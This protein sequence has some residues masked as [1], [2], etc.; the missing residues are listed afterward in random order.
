[1]GYK[2]IKNV[3]SDMTWSLSQDEVIICRIYIRNDEFLVY[4]TVDVLD[5][6]QLNQIISTIE[7]LEQ[8]KGTYNG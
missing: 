6:E 7:L 8:Q 2:L 5:K 4:R 3:M 1:M